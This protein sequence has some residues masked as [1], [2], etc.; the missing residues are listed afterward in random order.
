MNESTS[1]DGAGELS[2]LIAPYK[3][4]VTYVP[5]RGE[6]PFLDYLSLP[7]EAVK[8]QIAPRASLDPHEEAD[9][10]RRLMGDQPTCIFIPG[11]E[12][13]ATGA[14]H[15]RGAGWYDRFLA[16][17]PRDWLRVGFCFDT[18]YS[19]VPLSQE[20]WDQKMNAVCVVSGETVRVIETSATIPE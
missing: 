18:Q 12:F 10:A 13:D 9:I 15:G 7:K 20:E 4:F 19:N 11:R 2:A 17:V 5:L 1:V 3:G 14:R 8:Y 16:L 6:V